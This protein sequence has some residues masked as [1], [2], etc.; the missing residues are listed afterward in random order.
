MEW[1][2]DGHYTRSTPG[3]SGE[4]EL[5][6][7]PVIFP[8]NLSPLFQEFLN[9][10]GRCTPKVILPL[11]TMP[12]A[13]PSRAHPHGFSINA[14]THPTDIHILIDAENVNETIL[15]HELAHVW[16]DLVKGIED[17][18]VWDDQSD[19]PKCNQVMMIQSFVLDFAVDAVLREKGFDV[20]EIERDQ[21]IAS[22]QLALA[23]QKGVRFANLKE[24]SFIATHLARE[25]VNEAID[26][27]PVRS[28]ELFPAAASQLPEIYELS[29]IMAQIVLDNFPNDRQSAGTAIDQVLEASFN[30]TDPGLDFSSCL[31][32]VEPVVDWSFDKNPD[33]LE[34]MPVRDKCRVGV[35]MAKLGATSADTPVVKTMPDGRVIVEFEREDG[36]FIGGFVLKQGRPLMLP[37]RPQ[38]VPGPPQPLIV[39]S[40]NPPFQGQAWQPPTHLSTNQS[41]LRYSPRTYSPGLMRWL[42]GVRLDHFL[43]GEHPYAYADNNPTTLINPDGLDPV[44]D[45]FD[46]IFPPGL[47]IPE[48]IFPKGWNPCPRDKTP[49]PW[50]PGDW[51]TGFWS[52]GNCCGP[53]KPCGP[54]SKT[55][56][57][58]DAACK[59]HDN[60]VGPA[61]TFLQ[62]WFKCSGPYCND[63]KFCWN[64]HCVKRPLD[65]KQ[66]NAI[67]TMAGQFCNSFGGGPPQLEH[68]WK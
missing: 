12:F 37:L 43:A 38:R 68:P 56:D 14:W 47:Y 61:S 62:N 39:N 49:Q 52:Y 64:Q 19:L 54:F 63:L 36:S 18:R 24:S 17:A 5:S 20:E 2:V 45:L 59:K 7:Y 4:N 3:A 31:R 34:G 44:K 48:G 60:C 22:E 9:E 15:A 29:K 35:A 26:F 41:D 58:A 30:L 13:N 11:D 66:C 28:A 10:V 16:I 8:T 42:T 57:C 33:W 65:L 23:L 27:L 25:L 6:H 67:R 51:S 32:N 1:I 50:P 46:K 55:I 53:T 21:V 40:P